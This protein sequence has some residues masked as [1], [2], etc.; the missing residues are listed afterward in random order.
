MPGLTASSRRPSRGLR[1]FAP[2]AAIALVALLAGLSLGTSWLVARYLSDSALTASRL[3][4]VVFE[5]LNNP[6]PDAASSALLDL[7]A[8]VRELGIPLIVTDSAGAVTATANLTFEALPGDPRLIE[9]ARQ[10]DAINPPF[11]TPGLG[12]V[13]YGSLPASGLLRTLAILQALTLVVMVAVAVVAYRNATGAQ[14]DRLWVAM[15]REAAHQM[16]TPLTSLQG[17]IEQLRSEG[18]PP[19]KLAEMLDADAERLHRVAQRFERIGNPARRDPVALG[20]LAERVA[21][22]FR[23]RLPRHANRIGLEVLAPSAGPVILGDPVLLEW[24]LEAMVKNAVDA[25]QG[26]GGKIV[27]T[28]RAEGPEAILR[29]TDNGPGVPRE[30]RRTL[31]EPGITSKRGGWGIGLALARRVVADGHDGTLMLEPS[32]KGTT[33]VMRLPLA[34]PT[35]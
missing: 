20:A 3:Y 34:E 35:A 33:F 29:V 32:E 31:F 18:M 7:G 23:P 1:R 24:A 16:G 14:R 17:W 6:E 2:G 11:E 15:A 30:L 8:Q 26:R 12:A 4:S 9:A 25:L 28:V 10:L 13:H 5:A 21:G 27:L 19:Q 22:Y